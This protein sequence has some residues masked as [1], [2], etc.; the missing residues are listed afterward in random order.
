MLFS[1]SFENYRLTLGSQGKVLHPN[2]LLTQVLNQA[3]LIGSSLVAAST[4]R[5]HVMIC[6]KQCPEQIPL[7]HTF[8][9]GLR[10]VTRS[11]KLNPDR[12]ELCQCLQ[13]ALT[14]SQSCLSML[15][16]STCQ[17]VSTAASSA[18][19]GNEK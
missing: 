13:D 14:S 19:N 7:E 1:V 6:G 2:P 5:Y 10:L 4:E 17:W 3:G 12:A 8:P 9:S 16:L 18:V 15:F 11:T